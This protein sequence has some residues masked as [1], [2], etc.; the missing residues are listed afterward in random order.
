MNAERRETRVAE[1]RQCGLSGNYWYAV[2]LSKRRCIVHGRSR[3]GIGTS[4]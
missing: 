2:E 1:V 4:I 3:L